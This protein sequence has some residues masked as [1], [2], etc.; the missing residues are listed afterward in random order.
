M[1][2]G[3]VAKAPAGTFSFSEIYRLLI[4]HLLVPTRGYWFV[5]LTPKPL[6]SEDVEAITM[7]LGDEAAFRKIMSDARDKT[8]P[9]Q[10]ERFQKLLRENPP[11]PE[12]SGTT[13]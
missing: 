6:K 9:F 2:G 13:H 4:P 12:E 1:S 8:I 3:D 5:F 10:N 11:V 7:S